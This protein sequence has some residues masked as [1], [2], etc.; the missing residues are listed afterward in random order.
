MNNDDG[1]SLGPGLVD[2]EITREEVVQEVLNAPK[3][4]VRTPCFDWVAFP[5]TTMFHILRENV[6][7]DNEIT[8]L[9]DSVNLLQMHLT[10]VDHL[11]KQYKQ[12]VFSSTSR[13]RNVVHVHLF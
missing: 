8:R 1:R 6:K 3:R 12:A 4:R 13:C 2:L 10:V 7:V 5:L 11:T 9:T